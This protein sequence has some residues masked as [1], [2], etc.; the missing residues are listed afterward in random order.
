MDLISYH[1]SLVIQKIKAIQNSWHTFLSFINLQTLFLVYI[2][3]QLKELVDYG[4]N[5]Q[6]NISKYN[7]IYVEY[8][9]YLEK[10]FKTAIINTYLHEI[11]KQD[12]TIRQKQIMLKTL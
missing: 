9:I 4:K 2:P 1:F 8:Q 3:R 5:L 12:L 11:I 10:P 6:R 7:I